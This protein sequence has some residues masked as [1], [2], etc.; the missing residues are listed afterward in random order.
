M[1]QFNFKLN[2][3][4]LDSAQFFY[5]WQGFKPYQGYSGRAG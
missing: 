5:P 1:L 2:V 4:V 3:L